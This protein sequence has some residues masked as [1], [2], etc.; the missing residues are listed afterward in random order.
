MLCCVVLCCVVL[1]CVVLDDLNWETMNECIVLYCVVVWMGNEKVHAYI[2]SRFY[3]APEVIMEMEYG[4]EIDMWSFG[5]ILIEMHVGMPLF[6]GLDEADQLLRIATL[7][8]IPPD[9]LIESA[10]PKK[11]TAFFSRSDRGWRFLS[12]P[13]IVLFPLLSFSLIFSFSWSFLSSFSFSWSFLSL[14][15]S[16]SLIFLLSFHHLLLDHQQPQRKKTDKKIGKKKR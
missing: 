13:N 2:Q 16:P 5:C 10:S 15:H 9:H 11:R 1:C 8:G 6:P 3:R 4:P 14:Y 7:L 12:H